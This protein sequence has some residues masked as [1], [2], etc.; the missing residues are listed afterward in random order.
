M[1]KLFFLFLRLIFLGIM[2]SIFIYMNVLVQAQET[3]TMAQEITITDL[4]IKEDYEALNVDMV[5]PLVQ[6]IKDKRVEERINQTIQ[7]DVLN[8]KEMW[9]TES[10]KYLQGAKEEGWEIRKYE[11]FSYYIVHYQKDDLLSLS[12]FYYRYTLGAHG[13]TLQRAYNFNLENGE[14]ILLSD[15]LKEKEGYV[16]IINQEIKRQ[17]ELNPQEYFAEWSV[18]Q[19][20]SEEQPFYLIE[21]GIVVYF[22]L[23]EIAPYAS[24][25]RYFK[26]PYSLFGNS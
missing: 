22:G 18:F 11:A 3:K 20:I 13:H 2:A 24:G 23:Y 21:N 6:G 8:F 17:I 19:S 12:V 26:I 14:E 25:I 1:K 10:E 5:F 16:D 9:Q 7:K 15:I 4:V